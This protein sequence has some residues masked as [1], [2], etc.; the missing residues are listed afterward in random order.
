MPQF[1]MLLILVLLP[2]QLLSGGTRRGEHAAT[3]TGSDAGRT[4]TTSLPQD[5]L[6]C[7]AGR[8]G[9]DLAAVAG[10]YRHR[11]RAVRHA[12][13]RFRKTITLMA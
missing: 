13:A 7:I 1:G 11:R 9:R 8:A 10:H 4:T 5:R 12:L 2:L 6:Y 3:G